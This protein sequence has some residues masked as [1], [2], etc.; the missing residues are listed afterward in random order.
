MTASIETLQTPFY[1]D[2]GI[3]PRSYLSGLGSWPGLPTAECKLH[4][5][6]S[7]RKRIKKLVQDLEDA[8]SVE[9]AND[10]IAAQGTAK[11]LFQSPHEADILRG[12]ELNRQSLKMEMSKAIAARKR[13]AEIRHE[14][15]EFA[16]EL[17]LQMS[18]AL[19]PAFVADAHSVEAR[20]VRG[21][22]PLFSE[23]YNSGQQP[24]REWQLH[25]DFIL[26]G[27]FAGVWFLRFYWPIE[28]REQKYS[29]DP[30]L[31]WLIDLVKED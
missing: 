26:A 5:K 1:L 3:D 29:P 13:Q 27:S 23:P 31:G 21:N 30:G 17:A 16:S 4:L 25:Q 24:V 28:F 6:D 19:L 11:L 9:A 8:H 14:A 10:S 15:A 12:E 20:L 2:P 18:E 7:D 22:I